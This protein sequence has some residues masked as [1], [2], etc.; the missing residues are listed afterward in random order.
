MGLSLCELNF[1]L[2][3]HLIAEFTNAVMNGLI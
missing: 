2:T 3:I 1:T